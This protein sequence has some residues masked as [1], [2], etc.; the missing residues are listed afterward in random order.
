MHPV[1]WTDAAK[2]DLAEIAAYIARDSPR[3]AEHLIQRLRTVVLPLSDHPHLYPESRRM[4]GYREIVAHPNYLL[5]YRVLAN[6][7]SIE[8]V[9]HGRRNFPIH[10]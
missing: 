10:R 1:I 5:F 8:M 4:P 2:T 9:A 3:A 6:E 7:I